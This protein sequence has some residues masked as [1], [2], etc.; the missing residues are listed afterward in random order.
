[1]S[2]ISGKSKPVRAGLHHSGEFVS[3]LSNQD[4]SRHRPRQ[5]ALS[6]NK[7]LGGQTD[8]AKHMLDTVQGPAPS[9]S[10]LSGSSLT[11]R[12]KLYSQHSRVF[13]SR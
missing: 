3:N 5:Q 8:V 4:P 7:P 9:P 1:M 2:A 6:K 13:L 11:P 12:T 10:S